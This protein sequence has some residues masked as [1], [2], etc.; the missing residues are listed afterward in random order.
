V[1]ATYFLVPL[2]EISALALSAFGPVEAGLGHEFE[3]TCHSARSSCHDFEC[4]WVG[5]EPAFEGSPV[6]AE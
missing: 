1:P 4:A 3:K 6:P 2:S 5:H